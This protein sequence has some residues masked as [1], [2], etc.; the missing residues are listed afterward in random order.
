MRHQIKVLSLLLSLKISL[1]RHM[2]FMERTTFVGFII[3][4]EASQLLQLTLRREQRLAK[5]LPDYTVPKG[6]FMGL[7]MLPQ[8]EQIVREVSAP[9]MTLVS[10]ISVGPLTDYTVRP[11]LPMVYKITNPVHPDPPVIPFL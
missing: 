4:G 6:M 2:E 9:V 11:G 7:W 10:T 5:L 3:M 8:Q 1:L